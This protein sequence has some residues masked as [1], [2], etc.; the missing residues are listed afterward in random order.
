MPAA[1]LTKKLAQEAVDAVNTALKEGFFPKGESPP[2]GQK[3][4][5]ARGADYCGLNRKTF[6]SRIRAAE[7]YFGLVPDW[8]LYT[9][10]D[11]VVVKVTPPTRHKIRVYTGDMDE[12]EEPEY[13]VLGVGDLHDS[14]ALPEKDR[15]RWIGRYANEHAIPYIFQIGDFATFDSCSSFEDYGTISGRMKPSFENDIDSLEA[16][17]SA[18]VTQ[19]DDGYDPDRF[20]TMGNH[21]NRVYQWEDEHPEV[22]GMFGLRMEQ[23]FARGRFDYCQY[24][25]WKFLGGVGFTHVPMTIMGRPYGGKMPQNQ[26]ANDSIFSLV[27]GHS[28][29]GFVIGRPK[30]GPQKQITII[31][32]GCALPH[33][34]IEPYAKMS[35]TGWTYGIY[36]LAI[37]GNDIRSHRFIPM[38]ELEKMFG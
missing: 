33:G 8:S 18:M 23:A 1:K 13:R 38:R 30:I 37:R 36:D 28:H 11:P 34:H 10:P 17:I 35:T 19:F 22:E 12:S 26:I 27:Y 20:V 15:F 7:D 2:S 16:A 4:A 3:G 21:E 32:L 31:N 24:G 6:S 9:P 29:K 14:P 25:E 5:I